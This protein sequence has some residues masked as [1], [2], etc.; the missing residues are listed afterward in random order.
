[1]VFDFVIIF[2]YRLYFIATINIL[3]TTSKTRKIVKILFNFMIHN[4]SKVFILQVFISINGLFFF[5][6][7]FI[8]NNPKFISKN[9][10]FNKKYISI[11]FFIFLNITQFIN[12]LNQFIIKL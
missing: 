9:S 1:M 2:K 4:R 3:V 10:I 7:K 6:F 12:N 11:C 8:N 5:K